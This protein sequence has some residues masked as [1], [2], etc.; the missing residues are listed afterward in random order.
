MSFQ[1][2]D[3]MSMFLTRRRMSQVACTDLSRALSRKA[4]IATAAGS[5]A[6]VAAAVGEMVRPAHQRPISNRN[7][8]FR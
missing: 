5:A 3:P 1:Q 7:H 4:M 2:P 8:E 6:G